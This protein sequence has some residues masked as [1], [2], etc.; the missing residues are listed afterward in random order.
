MSENFITCRKVGDKRNG[1][2]NM[3]I[4]FVDRVYSTV[5]DAINYAMGNKIEKIAHNID[6]RISYIETADGETEFLT[7]TT[8]QNCGNLINPKED[9]NYYIN[10]YGWN[11]LEKGDK[12]TKNGQP[13]VGYKLVQSFEGIEDPLVINKIGR[14]LVKSI[15]PNHSAIIS[16]HTNTEHTHNHIVVCA[17]DLRGRKWNNCNKTYQQIRECSDRLCEEYGLPVLEKT[18]VQNLVKW[19]DADGE[20]HY[21]EPTKRKIEMLELKSKD[22]IYHED[23][24]S[25]VHT[26]AFFEKN[27]RREVDIGYTKQAIDE[28]IRYAISYEHMAELLEQMGFKIQSKK[29]NGEYRKFVMYKHPLA[30]KPVR[31]DAIDR[32][33][34][35][36][37]RNNLERFIAEQNKNAGRE[38]PYVGRY[39]YGTFNVQCFNKG[40]R[41]IFDGETRLETVLRTDKEKI[42]IKDIVKKDN[43]INSEKNEKKKNELI[44]Q[45]QESLDSLHY[46]ERTGFCS[47]E[48]IEKRK[49]YLQNQICSGNNS[50]KIFLEIENCRKCLTVLERLHREELEREK[51]RKELQEKANKSREAREEPKDKNFESAK[52]HGNRFI[53]MDEIKREIAKERN[54]RANNNTKLPQKHKK[55]ER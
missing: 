20:I 43:F 31:D 3:A 12:S 34:N 40:E 49:N 33:N 48:Q 17:W 14:Q 42:L 47:V 24:N 18:R 30:F 27:I 36:Y 32:K 23:V 15:F 55:W 8:F 44:R 53:T 45:I 19:Q 10:R 54:E 7:L 22:E 51:R 39:E 1:E 29:K 41:V 9:F 11:E 37:L 13:I 28:V 50:Q 16:T 2:I 25:Y 26:D 21:F 38:P 6:Y 52:S 35:F 46:I 5:N 4:T